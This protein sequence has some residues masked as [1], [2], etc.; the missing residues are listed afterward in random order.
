MIEDALKDA[1]QELDGLAGKVYKLAAPKSET[2]PFVVFG[3]HEDT[4]LQDMDGGTG[5]WIGVFEVHLLAASY[6]ELKGLEAKVKQKCR[7]LEGKTANGAMICEMRAAVADTEEALPNS[8]MEH[9]ELEVTATWQ[10]G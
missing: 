1:L 4:E 7:E 10:T 5:I 3:K 6:S 2:A 9:S 8:K